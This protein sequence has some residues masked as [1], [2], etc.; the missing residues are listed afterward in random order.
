MLLNPARTEN[1][2]MKRDK[3]KQLKVREPVDGSPVYAEPSTVASDLREL[4]ADATPEDVGRAL[5]Q[6]RDGL[7]Q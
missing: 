1:R 4:L 3:K 6:P 2:D 5:L 7:R